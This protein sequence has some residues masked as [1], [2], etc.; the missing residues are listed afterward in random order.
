[1]RDRDRVPGMITPARKLSP[2][3]LADF[4]DRVS[5]VDWNGPVRYLHP[6][7]KARRRLP[8][9]WRTRARLRGRRAVDGACAW[10]C[11]HGHE[12]AALRIWQM[13]GMVPR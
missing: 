7:G 10:L 6:D 8:L 1:V 2:E 11:G 9:P 13:L 5:R 3:E 4:L 12:Q